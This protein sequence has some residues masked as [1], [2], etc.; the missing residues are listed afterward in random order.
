MI[1]K[2]NQ[3]LNEELARWLGFTTNRHP[4]A[5]NILMWHNSHLGYYECFAPRFT[6]SFDLC[7][8]LLIP[9][10]PDGIRL[11]MLGQLRNG[12]GFFC[13]IGGKYLSHHYSEAETPAMA[14]CQAVKELKDRNG[15]NENR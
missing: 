8:E 10:F 14:F 11:R 1:D 9:R 13:S 3:I 5:E 6:G 15:K 2:E 4:N 12:K 7:I